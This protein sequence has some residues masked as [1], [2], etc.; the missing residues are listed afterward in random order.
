MGTTQVPGQE[1]NSDRLALLAEGIPGRQLELVASTI[2][3]KV[4]NIENRIIEALYAVLIQ[5]LRQRFDSSLSKLLSPC[6]A[7]EKALWV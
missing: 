2:T 3:Q 6:K 1:F 5:Q 7:K 4:S